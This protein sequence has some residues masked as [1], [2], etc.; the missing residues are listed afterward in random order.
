[1]G[2]PRAQHQSYRPFTTLT[3]RWNADIFGFN[4]TMFHVINMLLHGVA[5]VLFTIVCELICAKSSEVS[6]KYILHVYGREG[7]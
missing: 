5:T 3:F 7:V 2:S 4:P 1:M 6:R